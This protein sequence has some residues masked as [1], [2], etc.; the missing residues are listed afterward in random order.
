MNRDQIERPVLLVVRSEPIRA[1]FESEY[2]EWYAS[3]I[4]GLLRVSGVRT[5]QR[6]E[7]I[8]GDLRFMA[9]YD[10]QSPGVMDTP[11]YRQEAARFD[12]IAP[13]VRYTRNVYIEMP[14]AGPE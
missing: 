5:A 9:M 3:H 6:F 1:E 14:P 7:S 8:A 4:E 2:H 11:A 10:I 12:P 13:E